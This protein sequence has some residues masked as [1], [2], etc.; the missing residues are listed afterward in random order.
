MVNYYESMHQIRKAH[1]AV[2][3]YDLPVNCLLPSRLSILIQ[4]EHLLVTPL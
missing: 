4:F 1:P 3:F 2:I